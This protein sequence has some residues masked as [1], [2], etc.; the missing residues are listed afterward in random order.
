METKAP[1]RPLSYDEQKASEAAFL[2]HPVQEEWT[3]AAKE[4]YRKLSDAIQAHRK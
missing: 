2:G 1:V 3:M 4:I